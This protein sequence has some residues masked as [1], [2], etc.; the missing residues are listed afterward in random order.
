MHRSSLLLL[1]TPQI[2]AAPCAELDIS[3]WERLCHGLYTN[4]CIDVVQLSI[5]C[6]LAQ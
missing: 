3:F 1:P 6:Q 4:Y 2:S 5:V